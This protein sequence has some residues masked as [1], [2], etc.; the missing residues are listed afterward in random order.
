VCYE[1]KFSPI[2]VPTPTGFQFLNPA[3]SGSG[4][5]WNSG[6]LYNPTMDYCKLHQSPTASWRQQKQRGQSGVSRIFAKTVILD[7]DRTSGDRDELSPFGTIAG[8][9]SRVSPLHTQASKSFSV[10][11][12]VLLYLPILLLPSSTVHSK[13][14]LR[15]AGLVAGSGRISPTN[16]LLLVATVSCNAICP[17]RAMTSL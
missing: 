12:H 10:S 5:T 2:P 1:S 15:V 14:R 16:R 8:S 17:D 7:L 4:R 11:C 3:R 9:S 6:T 13:A